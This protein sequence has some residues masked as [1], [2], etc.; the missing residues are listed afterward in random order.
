MCLNNLVVQPED[1]DERER[2]ISR[3]RFQAVGETSL[4]RKS[5][6][7]GLFSTGKDALRMNCRSL[8]FSKSPEAVLGQNQKREQ[9]G[10]F[11][12]REESSILE[13]TKTPNLSR[14]LLQ[15]PARFS[16]SVLP[17][18]TKTIP[19]EHLTSTD[20]ASC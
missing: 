7:A 14:E 11:R 17:I 5:M 10:D 20:A 16:R 19:S 2:G 1:W 15:R 4:I 12:C 18:Q 8:L 9:G 3:Q 13:I 6:P